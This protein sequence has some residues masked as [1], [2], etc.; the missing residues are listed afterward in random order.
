MEETVTLHGLQ[1]QNIYHLIIYSL[2]TP[3]LSHLSFFQCEF[4][5]YINIDILY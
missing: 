1:S 3:I 2:P 5:V 4:L